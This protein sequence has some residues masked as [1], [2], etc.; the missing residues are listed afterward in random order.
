MFTSEQINRLCVISIENSQ[1]YKCFICT[2][3]LK[4]ILENNLGKID[5]ELYEEVRIKNNI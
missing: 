2:D 5:E 4:F 3:S 1:I